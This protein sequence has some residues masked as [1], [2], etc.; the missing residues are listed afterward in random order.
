M[1]ESLVL[2][3]GYHDRAFWAGWLGRLGCSDVGFRP[4]TAGYPRA[5]PWGAVRARLSLEDE[6]GRACNSPPAFAL[7]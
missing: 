3:E 4:G 5:D 7:I 1:S 6:L 2:C